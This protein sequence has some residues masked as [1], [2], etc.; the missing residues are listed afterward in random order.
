[1]IWLMVV[2]GGIAG[3][4]ARYLV[5]AAV[6]RL[7]APSS[8]PWGTIVVNVVGSAVLG[9]LAALMTHAQWQGLV[10]AA[11]GTGFCG[12]FTTF[13][14]FT[15]ETL[16][17]AEDGRPVAAAANVVMSLGLGLAAAAAGFLLL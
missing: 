14:A 12:A 13:S 10:Y 15:W 3:A 1:M 11:A 9:A 2:I 7:T 6:S 4:P 5:D 17:L 16:A 8:L